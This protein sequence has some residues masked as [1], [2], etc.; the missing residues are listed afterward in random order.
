MKFGTPFMEHPVYMKSS[1]GRVELS[2]KS[3]YRYSFF[4]PASCG[5]NTLTPVFQTLIDMLL[6]NNDCVLVR[7]IS[8][9]I[10]PVFV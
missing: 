3:F 9:S 4:C 10:E 5:D 8:I 2:F 6:R 1:F 7:T